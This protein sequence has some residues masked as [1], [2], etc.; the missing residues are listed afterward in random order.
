M[1]PRFLPVL[2]GSAAISLLSGC[3][4][5]EFFHRAYLIICKV[6]PEQQVA[7]EKEVQRYT[8]AV[9]KRERP[10]AKHRYIAVRT[11]DPNQKQR[12][13]YVKNREAEKKWDEDE[14]FLLSPD[15]VEPDQLHCVM[16]FDT[17]SKQFVGSGCYVV[18]Q[19]PADGQV[20]K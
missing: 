10:T 20:T 5:H 15:W 12:A 11:L 17:E 4:T 9:E 16:V 19:L 13:T 1:N 8:E 7:A 3:A 2:I 14:H 6:S 18:G